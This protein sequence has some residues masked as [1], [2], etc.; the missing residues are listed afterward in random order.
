MRPTR[1]R[2]PHAWIRTLAVLPLLAA[3]CSGGDGTGTGTG[4]NAGC[5]PAN[6]KVTIEFWSWVPGI[7]EAVDLWNAENPRIQVELRQ[8]P[9]GVSGTYQNYSNAVRAGQGAPDLGMIEYDTLPSFR[10][11]NALTDIGPC[12]AAAARDAFAD[13]TWPLV[14]FGE[15]EAVYGLP[16][17]TGPMV[18]YYRADL[19]REYGIE[20][21]ETWEDFAEATR[22]VRAR[23]ADVSLT[24][25][26]TTDVANWFAGL[27]WQNGAQWFQRDA[28]GWSV[29]ID[30]DATREVAEL[31]QGMIDEGTLSDVHS[32]S[33][34]WNRA[35]AEGELLSWVS[36]A[37]GGKLVELGAPST[38]GDWAVAPLPRWEPGA[39]TAANWGGSAYAVFA[40]SDHPYEA[41]RF[42]L[43]L[44]TQPEAV[45]ILNERGGAYPAALAGQELPALSAPQEFFG[46]QRVYQEVVNEAAADV[47]HD[48]VWGP[49][50]S[51][52]YATLQDEI[53]RVLDGD[54]TLPEA[55]AATQRQTVEDMEAQSLTVTTP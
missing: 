8:V 48:W 25:L 4:P 10:L 3:G 15:E 30:D 39:P 44:T 41:T 7:E 22:Q 5:E 2:R 19:F 40:T 55:V 21:P 1:K 17:D 11:Q 54:Q 20:V 18:M 36:A 47:D 27:A 50:M 23:D 43:W 9:D 35:L 13:F 32:Y 34:A 12:G 28:E 16:Q 45:E 37:W 42:A 33:E 46:G 53:A 31:W 49:T 14:T 24:N 38:A 6:E 29:S 51:A 26:A 52:T